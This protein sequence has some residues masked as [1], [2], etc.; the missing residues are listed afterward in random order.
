MT[1]TM[2]T[3]KRSGL[4]LCL[5]LS[6]AIVCG[7]QEQQ[8]P[9][10]APAPDAPTTTGTGTAGKITKFTA[11]TV[12]GDSVMT[13]NASKIGIN[14]APPTATLHVNGTQPAPLATNG[15]NAA[16]LLQTSGG[17]GGNTTAAGKTGGK[18]ASIALVAGQ[19]G[20]APSG[21]TNGTGGS[22]TL[23]PG[24]AGTGGAGGL[25]GNVLIAPTNDG[26]VGIG[27]N[28]PKS[29]LT[30]QGYVTTG[31][32]LDVY[33]GSGSGLSDNY[34]VG[35]H[36]AFGDGVRGLTTNG[37]GVYGEGNIGVTGASIGSGDGVVGTASS[38]RGVVGRSATA[39][40]VLGTSADALGGSS[41]SGIGVYGIS[42]KGVGVQ[43]ESTSNYGVYGKTTGSK[44]AVY[45]DGTVTG[46]FGHTATGEGVLGHS[47]SNVGVSGTSF[48]GDGVRGQSN[49]GY[50]GNFTGKSRF[51]GNMEIGGN[52]L[53]GATTRQMLNLYNTD[54]GIG[55]QASTL[56][57]RVANTGGYNWY[58][59]GVHNNTQNSP[60]T[61]GTSLMRLD[62]AG[63][64][65]TKGAVNPVSDRNAKANFAAVN[66]RFILDQLA[67]V[68]IRTWNYKTDSDTV[69]HIGPVAQD[70]RAA[71]N[72][73]A[74]DLHISTV[75]AD[76]VALAAIQGLYQLILEKEKQNEEKDRKI[77]ELARKLEE[78][79]TQLAEVKRDSRR[80]RATR[81]RR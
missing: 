31:G 12:L 9:T 14:V 15:A 1:T 7:A 62:S 21:G 61:G 73:G 40:G 55:I 6:F 57:F 24:S 28:D 42:L 64:L 59:G 58:M 71:F 11:A 25:P 37:R 30:V 17:K 56:Y 18:G 79:Q 29:K 78:M 54:Y 35:G 32:V 33:Q 16:T 48:S 19:G 26:N 75:D 66:P 43:G 36:S 44:P 68:P 60:G 72:L 38:G 49:S 2:T 45:G 74:D 5:L 27:I 50:A 3:I 80:Q 22:I 10:P 81:R 63:N 67:A 47:D 4:A 46:V 52:E 13:E 23:Q 20:N 53:F 76:G 8:Q 69:R 41:V 65:F 51:T 70:F 77:D 39:I 34:A